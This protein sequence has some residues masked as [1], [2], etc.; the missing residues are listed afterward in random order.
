MNTGL[1][2]VYL[3]FRLAAFSYFAVA[4]Y[5]IWLTGGEPPS[6][7]LMSFSGDSGAAA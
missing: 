6:S 3:R 7:A 5:G 2:L 1:T 4:T